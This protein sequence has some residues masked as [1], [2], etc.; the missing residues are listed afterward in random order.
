MAYYK[1]CYF[2]EHTGEDYNPCGWSC[3]KEYDSHYLCSKEGKCHSI[4]DKPPKDFYFQIF[5]FEV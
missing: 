2:C 3:I 1:Y 5:L 4:Y